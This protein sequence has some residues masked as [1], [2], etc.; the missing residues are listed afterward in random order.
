[1]KLVCISDT[2]LQLEDN[3]IELPIGDVLI[4]SGDAL[5]FGNMDE[6]IIFKNYLLSQK[7]KFKYILYVP[8]NHDRIF[9]YNPELAINLLKEVNN[10]IVL[11]DNE[12]VI[13]GIKFYGTS[14]H[15]KFGSWSFGIERGQELKRKYDLIPD[16]TNVLITHCP[17]Y[18]ILDVAP[19]NS[20]NKEPLHVGSEELL[21]KINNLTKL[22]AHIFGHIHNSAGQV[23]INNVKYINAAICNEKYK[24]INKVIIYEIN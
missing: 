2:H 20:F 9:E 19:V 18:K 1:M 11:Q 15:P 23:N 12:I 8:G 3:Y 24:P 4:H 6:L 17:P 5:S 16:D 21:E 10:L 14:W 7:H 22:Q 13:N